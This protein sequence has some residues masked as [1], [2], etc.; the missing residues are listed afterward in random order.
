M[1]HD[2]RHKME[3]K[4]RGSTKNMKKAHELRGV[5]KKKPVSL[6]NQIRGIQRLL[7]KARLLS[8]IIVSAP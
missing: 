2:V 8:R 5:V 4:M 3:N 6:K 1:A 7:K